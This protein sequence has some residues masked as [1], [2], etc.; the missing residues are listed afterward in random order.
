[1]NVLKTIVAAATISLAASFAP[2]PVQAQPEAAFAQS[3][4]MSAGSRAAQIRQLDQV[5][6]I[7]VIRLDFRYVST[8]Y[9]DNE[10]DPAYFRRIAERNSAGIAKLRAALRANPVTR[11]AL[12]ARGIPINRIV[13]VNI[14]SRGA[15]RLYYL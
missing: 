13:G 6:A 2:A 3:A 12:A 1:M 11:K 7:G 10:E 4:M 15:L 9:N 14:G 5:P 8:K